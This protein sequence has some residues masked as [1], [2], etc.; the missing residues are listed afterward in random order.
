MSCSSDNHR[1][2]R[3]LSHLVHPPPRNT[4]PTEICTSEAFPATSLTD[5]ENIYGLMVVCMKVIGKEVKHLSVDGS[6]G[7]L[8][9]RNFP[10]ICIRE[11]DGEAGDITCDIIDNAEASMLYRDVTGLGRDEIRQLRRNSCCFNGGEAKK[12]SQ[13]ILEGHKNYD[14]MLNH[15][16]DVV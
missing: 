15:Q 14:L 11:S 6:R 16:L 8:M 4:S 9:E 5:L 13:M 10:R 1:L 12:P 7:S 2:R 3:G